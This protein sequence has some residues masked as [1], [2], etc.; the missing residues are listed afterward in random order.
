[1]PGAIFT[2][3]LKLAL[4]CINKADLRRNAGVAAENLIRHARRMIT[5]AA[6]CPET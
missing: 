2:H 5:R 3:S 6:G 4:I 1:M